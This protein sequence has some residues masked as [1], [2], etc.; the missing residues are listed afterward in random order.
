MHKTQQGLLSTRSNQNDPDLGYK[1]DDMNLPQEAHSGIE[2]NSFCFAVLADTIKGTIYI[3]LIFRFPVR[4]VQSMQY[5]FVCYAY[6][7]NSILVRHM[8]DR[9]NK[10][11][12]ASYKDV[13]E[14]LEGRGYK[15]TLNVTDNEFSKAV[16]NYVSS[17][18]VN[19]KLVET[20]NH[21]VNAAERAIQTFKNNFIS[22]LCTIDPIYHLQLW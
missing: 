18:D 16:Q 19:W 4:S 1:P 13:Y 17:Q 21:Q 15:P 14:Y 9:S 10:S 2:R 3:D 22:G 7:P 20:D 6:E 11:F 8:K 12:L 5:I